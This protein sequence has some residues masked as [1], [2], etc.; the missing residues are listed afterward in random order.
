M[1][2]TLLT[3]VLGVFL[4]IIA[5]TVGPGC[6]LR[7]PAAE[8]PAADTT[9]DTP[10]TTPAG[11]EDMFFKKKD[12]GLLAV[13]SPAPDFSVPDQDGKIRKLSDYKGTRVLLWFYPKADTPG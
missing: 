7:D 8:P 1:T 9:D 10:E 12:D 11:D 3:C 13:G 6:G 2:R 5:V 4:T